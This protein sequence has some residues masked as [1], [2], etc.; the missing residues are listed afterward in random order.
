[1][2]ARGARTNG[3]APAAAARPKT[4]AG[5]VEA[6][7]ELAKSLGLDAVLVAVERRPSGDDGIAV[8]RLGGLRALELVTTLEIARAVAAQ[9]VGLQAPAAA[10]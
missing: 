4:H 6:V 8:V 2:G 10:E 3:R 5:R 1:M 7:T 9:S